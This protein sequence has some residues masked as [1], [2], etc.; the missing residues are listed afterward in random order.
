MIK[1]KKGL[2]G[3]GVSAM[4]LFDQEFIPRIDE[5][6]LFTFTYGFYRWPYAFIR[7]RRCNGLLSFERTFLN[8]N[9]WQS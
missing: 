7:Y 9:P 2:K 3:W 8:P 5:S 4:E 6:L 1:I